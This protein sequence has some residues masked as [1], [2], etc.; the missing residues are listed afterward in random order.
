MF[1]PYLRISR[2]FL[3]LPCICLHII[4]KLLRPKSPFR[5][6]A[7]F[8]D[9]EARCKKNLVMKL[10]HTFITFT[11]R[12]QLLQFHHFFSFQSQDRGFLCQILFSNTG[13]I[14]CFTYTL[15]RLWYLIFR[16]GFFKFIKRE[17][18]DSRYHLDHT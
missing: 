8:D 6:L 17:D 5:V 10:I 16:E 18:L 12:S 1:P 11:Q 2:K 4:V 14:S 7:G 15:C 3:Q 9:N 13:I